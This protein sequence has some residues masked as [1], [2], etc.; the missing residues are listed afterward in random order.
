MSLALFVV[1]DVLLEKAC[2]FR[3][4]SPSSI[5]FLLARHSRNSF[6]RHGHSILTLQAHGACCWA[7]DMVP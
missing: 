1:G 7:Q 5:R 3:Y 4:N 2:P 6:K